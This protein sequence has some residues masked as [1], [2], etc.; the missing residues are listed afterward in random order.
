[1]TASSSHP[2]QVICLSIITLE[3]T[4][5]YGSAGGGYTSENIL[6]KALVKVWCDGSNNLLSNNLLIPINR[7]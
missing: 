4:V 3:L 7:Y 6:K 5:W 1:M 2:S